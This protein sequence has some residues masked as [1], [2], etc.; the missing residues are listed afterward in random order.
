[1]TK[2]RVNTS[3][4]E[5]TTAQNDRLSDRGHLVSG[6]RGALSVII[7]GIGSVLVTP[8]YSQENT[9][10]GSDS[11]ATVKPKPPEVT[12]LLEPEPKNFANGT[13][14]FAELSDQPPLWFCEPIGTLRDAKTKSV[15]AQPSSLLEITL[16]L[17]DGLLSKIK[18]E[19]EHRMDREPKIIDWMKKTGLFANDAKSTSALAREIALK[20]EV[21]MVVLQAIH[22]SDS[23]LPIFI[24]GV[25]LEESSPS[26]QNLERWKNLHEKMAKISIDI[27]SVVKEEAAAGK[28][29]K[30]CSKPRKPVG[31]ADTAWLLTGAMNISEEEL[32]VEYE[33]LPPT[34]RPAPYTCYPKCNKNDP[35]PCSSLVENSR[36]LKSLVEQHLRAALRRAE[37]FYSAEESYSSRRDEPQKANRLRAIA[38]G[39]RQQNDSLI[40]KLKSILDRTIELEQEIIDVQYAESQMAQK[41]KRCRLNEK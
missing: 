30:R 33:N 8:A 12:S 32:F 21:A 18:E 17:E 27:Q 39:V 35:D 29:Q 41:L 31:V 1:V 11:T 3:R 36:Y 38:F 37:A 22:S 24:E 6:F 16:L 28:S 34:L 5:R 2:N 13:D 40:A 26:Q 25:G 7:I 20:H 9:D 19:T 4:I 14:P 15:E 10:A 23:R